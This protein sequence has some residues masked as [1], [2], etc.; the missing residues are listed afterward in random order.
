MKF[1]MILAILAL[2]LA[3]PANA[4]TAPSSAAANNGIGAPQ[5]TQSA[6][7][8]TPG[9]LWLLRTLSLRREG[10]A[11]QERDGG[12]LTPEHYAMLQTRFDRING[13]DIAGRNPAKAKRK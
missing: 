9:Q 13:R 10:L 1:H 6:T 12:T 11:L 5:G 4:Q 8:V 3:L 2:A 7:P